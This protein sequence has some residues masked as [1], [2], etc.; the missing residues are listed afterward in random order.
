MLVVFVEEY[1]EKTETRWGKE[2]FD[3]CIPEG[4][5]QVWGCSAVSVVREV[6][7]Q[8]MLRFQIAQSTEVRRIRTSRRDSNKLVGGHGLGHD[9]P[10]Y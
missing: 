8:E 1:S 9:G 3:Q 7:F 10:R 2:A 6:V 4:T 5:L